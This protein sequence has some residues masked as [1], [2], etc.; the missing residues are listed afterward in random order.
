MY[1]VAFFDL[2]I[3]QRIKHFVTNPATRSAGIFFLINAIIFSNY[4]VRLPDIKHRLDIDDGQL[5]IAMLFSPLG[6]VVFTPLVMVLMNK[7][8][9]GR[10][11]VLTVLGTCFSILV[12]AVPTTYI[13]VCIAFF[14]YGIFHGGPPQRLPANPRR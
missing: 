8:G 5:G 9:T 14:C 13:G 3:L 12:L 4:A 6:V 1:I 10:L 2:M 11:S 7:Y